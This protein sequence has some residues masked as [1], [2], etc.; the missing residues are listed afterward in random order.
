MKDDGRNRGDGGEGDFNS[1]FKEVR[2]G[3]LPFE[4]LLALIAR[5]MRQ[6][7]AHYAQD[8]PEDVFQELCRR[9]YISLRN[10]KLDGVDGEEAFFRWVSKVARN[11]SIDM[12]RADHKLGRPDDTPVEDHVIRDPKST[13]P[14]FEYDI[15]E[16]LNSLSPLYQAIVQ[17]LMENEGVS[18]RE[19]SKLLLEVGFERSHTAVLQ[20]RNKIRESLNSFLKRR[21][22]S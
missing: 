17:I 1:T 22:R 16:W 3:S 6:I 14:D 13:A 12:Y 15:K 20:D 21:R 11:I 19:I 5:R 7:C 8:H 9:L 2:N 4:A 18:A 10:G